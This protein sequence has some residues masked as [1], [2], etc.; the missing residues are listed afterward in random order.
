MPLRRTTRLQRDRAQPPA[1]DP[2][3]PLLTAVKHTLTPQAWGIDPPLE[4]TYWA[5]TQQGCPL[6]ASFKLHLPGVLQLKGEIRGS[7]FYPETRALSYPLLSSASCS[8]HL[9]RPAPIQS[10]SSQEA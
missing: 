2:L 9:S 10:W 3:P 8:F 1:L 5:P 6:R 7:V 4:L